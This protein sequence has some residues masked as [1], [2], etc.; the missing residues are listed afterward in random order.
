MRLSVR[1]N[2]TGLSQQIKIHPSRH[3]CEIPC[4]RSNP[5]CTKNNINIPFLSETLIM[6]AKF[7]LDM[8]CAPWFSGPSAPTW[9]VFPHTKAT[10]PCILTLRQGKPLP[11]ASALALTDFP[12]RRGTARWF[13]T[14]Q[15]L[16]TECRYISSPLLRNWI[17]F[18]FLLPPPPPLRSLVSSYDN[19]VFPAVFLNSQ[20]DL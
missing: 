16:P 7:M 12:W 17:S 6:W 20:E 15:P 14:C 5:V 13:R 18:L 3:P 10:K 1:D 4:W 8:S 11:T 2:P 19:L 9:L